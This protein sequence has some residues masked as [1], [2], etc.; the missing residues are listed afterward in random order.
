MAK[1]KHGQSGKKCS[2]SYASWCAMKARCL[3]PNTSHF[4]DYGGRG[5]KVCERW[6]KFEN[7]FC[8]MGHRTKGMTLGRINNDGN[9]EPENCRWETW[10]QQSKNKRNGNFS[11]RRFNRKSWIKTG[12]RFSSK[13]KPGTWA[14]RLRDW[15]KLLNVI[16]SEAAEKLG[17]KLR[18][19]QGWESGRGTPHPLAQSELI[20][21]MGS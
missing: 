15:R 4:N 17:V 7:F 5:I 9:Y 16:Q 14:F 6:M 2:L 10:K 3:N 12:P 11:L 20:R 21:R 18:T 1:I 13:L 19:F 8:D